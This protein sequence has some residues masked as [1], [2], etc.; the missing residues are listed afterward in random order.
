[1]SGYPQG[2]E[3]TAE[4]VPQ[5][6]SIV[7]AV[8][9]MW[10]G[11]ALSALG[12]VVGLLTLGSLKDNIKDQ[13][14]K[15]NT[16]LSQSDLDTAY[17]VGVATLVV[18]GVL[19]IGLWLWMAW[20]NGN[21]RKWARIVATVLGTLNVIFTLISLAQGE[22]PVV[23]VILSVIGVGLAVVI[24]ILLWRRESTD[25]YNARSRPKFA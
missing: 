12:L 19:G 3:P 10:A 5:P 14:A 9:L 1:M 24:L 25:F 8:R 7:T 23:S 11:A 13:L 4:A 16:T 20:A 17:N 6:S 18:V 21:G 15:D 22:T 2:S